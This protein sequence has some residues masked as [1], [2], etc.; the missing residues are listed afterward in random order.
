M[1][2][3]LEW[4]FVSG[5]GSFYYDKGSDTYGVKYGDGREDSDSREFSSADDAESFY[6]S[7]QPESLSCS[8][9]LWQYVGGSLPELIFCHETREAS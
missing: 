3:Q 4:E 6:S 8:K 5:S 7:I 9:A 2:K 1:K